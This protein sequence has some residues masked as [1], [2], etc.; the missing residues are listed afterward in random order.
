[1]KRKRGLLAL[2]LAG[3]G[4]KAAVDEEYIIYIYIPHCSQEE[5]TTR[6]GR[7]TG[8]SRNVTPIFTQLLHVFIVRLLSGTIGILPVTCC[9][10][11]RIAPV[12]R[13]VSSFPDASVEK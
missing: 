7:S 8:K 6:L 11:Y 10:S 3:G 2:M 1:M 12:F 5:E 4:G 13:F 9:L